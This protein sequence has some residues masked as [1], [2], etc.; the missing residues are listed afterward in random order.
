MTAMKQRGLTLIEVMI[1][2]AIGAVLLSLALP[3]FTGHLQRHRLKAA[4]QS[5]A[6]DLAEARFEAARRG[7]TLHLVYATGA[8]WCWAIATRADCSC[9]VA[10]QCR[11]KTMRAG[12]ARGVVLTEAA[13]SSFEPATG[14]PGAEQRHALLQTSSTADRLRVDVTPLGRARICAPDGAMGQIPAC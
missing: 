6:A 2:V 1:V 5:L 13:A 14:T 12:D 9:H 4:A 7:Q 11:L 3:S 8:D 10:Q